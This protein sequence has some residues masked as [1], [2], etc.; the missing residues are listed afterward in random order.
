MKERPVLFSAPMVRTILEG[1]KTQTRRIVA[2]PRK[3]DWYVVVDHGNG[4]WPYQSDDGE[5]D[6]CDD[7]MEHPYI[8]PYGQPGDR[9]WV[10]ETWRPRLALSPWDVV[11]TYAADGQ[12]RTIKDGDF[13]DRDWTMPK[14]AVH[15]NVTPLFM[16]RWAS[17]ITL[18][19]T[20]VRVER[21]QDISEADAK[22]EGVEGHYIKDGWY[23][24]NYSLSNEDAST[25]PMLTNAKDSYRT[26]WE[27][28]NSPGS[29]AANPWV[30]VVSFRRLDL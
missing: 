8:C 12:Q 10:K 25:S 27:K 21:L 4:W 19:V 2:M 3:R 17:R 13:G 29:W 11:I 18:E 28:L 5:S 26:L 7:S 15:G 6:L 1:K 20:D 30:W 22:A 9:L 16:P 24:R 23:W 14:A